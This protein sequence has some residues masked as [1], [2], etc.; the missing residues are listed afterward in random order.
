MITMGN[1]IKKC[2]DVENARIGWKNFA[3]KAGKFNKEGERDFTVFLDEE[4]GLRLAEDGWNVGFLE[5]REPGDSRTAKLQVKVSY[6]GVPPKVVLIS[7]NSQQLLDE[8]SISML[9]WVEMA[10]VDLII[11][12]YNWTMYEGTKN[13]KHGVSAY[14][15][16]IYVTAVVDTFE[17]KYRT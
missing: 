12:P 11:N 9:D 16:A 17:E 13:E 6:K 7:G 3:G 8:E 10:N 5:P 14:L 15:K 2:I 1:F 4:T